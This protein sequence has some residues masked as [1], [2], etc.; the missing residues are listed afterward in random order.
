MNNVRDNVEKLRYELV[1]DD[2]LA[3]AQYTL[4]RGVLTFTHTVM[5]K[6]LQGK[7]VGSRLIAAAVKDARARR[8][9]VVARCPFVKA[10]FAKHPEAQ[11][12]LQR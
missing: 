10:W 7:G 12:L 8:L 1:V 4:D 2:T 6:A 3:I 11:D 9:K 5:P